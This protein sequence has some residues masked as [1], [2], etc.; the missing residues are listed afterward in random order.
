[1]EEYEAIH[2][3]IKRG[4]IIGVTGR[5]SRTHMKE[6]SISPTEIVL[7]TPNLHQLPKSH[8]GLKDVE[9][10]YRK[11]YLDLIMNE[12]TRNIFVTRSKVVNYI[13][14]FLDSLGF[15]EVSLDLR[16]SRYTN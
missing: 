2:N 4:D 15:L 7:L 9:T 16:H 10:R 14:R 12:N 5:P 6:L 3:L 13:R 8:F 1:V 11:R